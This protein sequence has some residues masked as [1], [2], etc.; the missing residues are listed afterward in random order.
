MHQL[1]NTAEAAWDVAA[2]PGLLLLAL[3][4]APRPL[5]ERVRAAVNPWLARVVPRQLGWVSGACCALPCAR[6]SRPCAESDATR[7][8]GKAASMLA[9]LCTAHTV[10]TSGHP[11][12][13]G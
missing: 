8:A 9:V 7:Q 6:S 10:S 2:V 4:L 12:F 5:H 11:S 1:L 13:C 3:C